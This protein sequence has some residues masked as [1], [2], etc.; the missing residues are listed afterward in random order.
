QKVHLKSYFAQVTADLFDHVYLAA[1]IRNDGASTFGADSRRAW[2][3]KGSAAW[4]FHAPHARTGFITYGKLRMAYWQSG[5]QPPPYLPPSV[6][7]PTPTQIAGSGGLV[8]GPTPPTTTLGPERVKEFEAGIDL[9]FWGDK[10]DL[11]V[12][13]YRQNTDDAI[14]QVPVGTSTGY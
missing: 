11:S 14:L 13:H 10:A 1:A 12:T 6:F 8:S 2:F 5:T 4:A 7:T 3:P 9:G